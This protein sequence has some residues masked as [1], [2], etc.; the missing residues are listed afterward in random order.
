MSADTGRVTISRFSFDTD[1][2]KQVLPETVVFCMLQSRWLAV[3]DIPFSLS[4]TK[5]SNSATSCWVL[6]SKGTPLM[7]DRLRFKAHKRLDGS[8]VLV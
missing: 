4:K 6:K 7:T 5:C 2:Q 8:T 1:E 3:I